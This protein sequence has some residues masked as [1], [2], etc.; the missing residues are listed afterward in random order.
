MKF[1]TL[2]DDMEY[3]KNKYHRTD[4]PFDPFRRME[5][6]GYEYDVNTGMSDEEI[7]KALKEIYENTKQ[8]PH[9][10]S[11]AQ[12][13]K[14]IL[15]NARI[16]INEHDYFVGFYN[17]GRLLNKDFINNHYAEVMNSKL[18]SETR[19]FMT[20][21]KNKGIM[22]IWMDYDHSV[23]DW[24]AL[25]TLGFTGIRSRARAYRSRIENITEEQEAFFEAIETEY[26][27]IID[28]I[29]RMYRHALKMTH[30]KA[31]I[32]AQSLKTLRDGA[33]QTTYDVLQMIYLY[34]IL[35]ECVDSYQVRSL[36]SGLD[37]NL[38]EYYKKDIEEKRF[39]KEEISE[40]IAYFLMQFSAI[41]NYWGHP[42]YM[43]G[44]D[45]K[46]NTLINDVSYIILD[47]YKELKIYN[48]KIQIKYSDAL[49]K[50]F[51]FS[52]LDLIRSGVSSFVFVCEDC[53]TKAL[54]KAG[55][56]YVD[57]ATADIRGC[58][59][60]GARGKEGTT[61]PIYINMLAGVNEALKEGKADTYEEFKSSYYKIMTKYFKGAVRAV[62]E[63]EKYMAYVNPSSMFSATVENS[64]KNGKDAFYNGAV[65]NNTSMI[66]SGTASAVDAL[67]AVK[68]LMY[69]N[70]FTCRDELLKA[71]IDNWEGY[72]DLLA[73]AKACPHKY[74]NSDMEAD[75]CTEEIADF[76]SSFQGIPNSRNGIYKMAIHSAR[77]FIVFGERSG[78]TPDGRMAGDE[79]SKNASPSVG[80]DKNGVTA[81]I[82]SVLKMKPYRFT[83]GC[84][85]DIMLHPTAVSGEE[86]LVAMKGLLDVYNKNGG[87][88]MQFNILDANMLRDAQQNPERYDNLQVRVCGWNVL[89][90]NMCK[91]EQDA[92]IERAMLQ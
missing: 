3:L 53:V 6:H 30:E 19:E 46:G 60:Y 62:N 71:L 70:R 50:K 88:S 23:P 4:Q 56:T 49:P 33:P 59:E 65:Y 29:D 35:S 77:H 9:P 73:K 21:A 86:G 41:G 67:L 43:G 47:I 44:K 83:E 87:A 20:E 61:G 16:D 37:V 2:Y 48:P 75:K 17:W 51:V 38:Y 7:G 12:A 58:Y 18:S 5:Y 84:T 15:D 39:T 72:S 91:K 42:F 52:V 31:G 1:K 36:G 63:L 68:Y 66:I 92:Y 55:E 90:N 57:A 81:L 32:I 14:Y 22:D 82:M 80:G 76:I 11:K 24:N 26:T 74:G 13:F 89:F 25:Y 34:F 28:L 69:D 79:I 54:M 85:V 45:L 8:L 10:I 40:F 78:A 27:A 64:V